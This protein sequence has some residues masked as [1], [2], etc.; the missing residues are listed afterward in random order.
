M[1]QLRHKFISSPSCF[2]WELQ[3][4]GAVSVQPNAI[5]TA[6]PDLISQ[7]LRIGNPEPPS[8]TYRYIQR[9]AA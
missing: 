4:Q 2:C 9:L 7:Q 6:A 1:T 5:I 8:L 3:A